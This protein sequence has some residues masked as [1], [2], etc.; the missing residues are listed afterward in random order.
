M[1]FR[2][3]AA[4]VEGVLS[5]GEDYDT[6]LRPSLVPYIETANVLVDEVI[7]HAAAKGEALTAKRAELLERWLAAHFYCSSDQPYKQRSTLRAQ[8]TFQGQTGM[9]LEATKYG[10]AALLLDTTGS[11][12][13]ITGTSSVIKRTVGLDW[14]G[15]SPTDQIPYRDRD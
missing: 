7:D 9:Y 12:S 15:K 8:G 10:Q 4:A 14:L 3:S 11:L 1:A 2:T 5:A 13:T 6:V